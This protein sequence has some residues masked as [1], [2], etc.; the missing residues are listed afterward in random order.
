MCNSANLYENVQAAELVAGSRVERLFEG[1]G[2]SELPL[3]HPAS[4]LYRGRTWF[5]RLRAVVVLRPQP[6][7]RGDFADEIH[8]PRHD[9]AVATHLKSLRLDH[10]MA[11]DG[12]PLHMVGVVVT[13]AVVAAAKVVLNVAVQRVRNHYCPGP[14]KPSRYQLQRILKV[15]QNLAEH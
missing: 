4:K 8:A 3:L 6:H 1:H 7:S 11:A 9:D 12:K 10:A 14:G 13:P 5:L 15:F 2:P